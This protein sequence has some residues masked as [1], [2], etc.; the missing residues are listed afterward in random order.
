MHTIEY[1][2]DSEKVARDI[3]EARLQKSVYDGYSGD[4]T[5]FGIPLTKAGDSI[6]I[7]D[8]NEP[9]REGRYLIEKVTKTY[10]SDGINRKNDLAF[11]I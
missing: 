2:A 6:S 7:K 1:A 10:G 5:G 8:N 9:Y 3:A 4:I 11:K